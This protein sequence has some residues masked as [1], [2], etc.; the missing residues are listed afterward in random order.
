MRKK[1]E[2][3]ESDLAAQVLKYDNAVTDIQRQTEE[4]KLKMT[5]EKDRLRDLEDYFNKI[6][7]NLKYR[8]LELEILSALCERKM[9]AITSLDQASCNLQKIARP[10]SGIQ[11]RGTTH[12]AG[13]R[14]AITCIQ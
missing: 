5:E 1:K 8:K 14:Q 7:A 11:L 4:T 9:V 13:A 2:R 6:D 10:E 3:I 12:I